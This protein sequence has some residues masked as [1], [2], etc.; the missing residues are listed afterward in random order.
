MASKNPVAS[1]VAA[2]GDA[3]SELASRISGLEYTFRQGAT[4]RVGSGVGGFSLQ[5]WQPVLAGGPVFSAG[6]V[7]HLAP[8][9]K[10]PLGL[11]DL[12]SGFI[13][14]GRTTAAVAAPEM[15]SAAWEPGTRTKSG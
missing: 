11:A 9:G 7:D 6:P 12:T 5:G 3:L 1:E 13:S 4:A 10:L 2:L 8:I 14:A 15:N